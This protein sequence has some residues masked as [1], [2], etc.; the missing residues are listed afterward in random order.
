MSDLWIRLTISGLG[1]GRF[2]SN[3][4]RWKQ[5]LILSDLMS[6]FRE[7]IIVATLFR[8]EFWWICLVAPLGHSLTPNTTIL[9]FLLWL[10][11]EAPFC[12]LLEAAWVGIGCSYSQRSRYGWSW[13]DGSGSWC[14][15]FILRGLVVFLRRARFEVFMRWA[16][17]RFEINRD[18]TSPLRVSTVFTSGKLTIFFRPHEGHVQESLES[19]RIV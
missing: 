4:P 6:V 15:S 10:I 11:G 14:H 9:N 17:A 3:L 2:G 1:W 8:S 16:I 7:E 12:W 18:A 13:W 5:S 19:D